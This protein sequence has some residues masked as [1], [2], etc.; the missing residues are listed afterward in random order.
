MCV[1]EANTVSQSVIHN[2]VVRQICGA[3]V[4]EQRRISKVYTETIMTV[5]FAGNGNG[6]EAIRPHQQ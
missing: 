1:S 2:S 6:R 5:L 4:G 3:G